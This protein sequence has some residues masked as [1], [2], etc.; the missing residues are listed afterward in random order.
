[1]NN[2]PEAATD[3]AGD[4]DLLGLY[5]NDVK[6]ETKKAVQLMDIEEDYDPSAEQDEAFRGQQWD[7][8]GAN[9]HDI[10][11]DGIPADCALNYISTFGKIST[12][13]QFKVLFTIQ[14][15]S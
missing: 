4:G 15:D 2:E 5:S 1:M 7:S 3:F 10:S 13:E 14:N 12:G 11:Y 8:I 9:R 6:E